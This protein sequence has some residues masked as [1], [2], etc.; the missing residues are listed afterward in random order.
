MTTDGMLYV[1]FVVL[2]SIFGLLSAFFLVNTDQ[3]LNIDA[4]P[5]P[6]DVAVPFLKVL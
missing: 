4:S 5:F 6:R 2:V 3:Y 1:V